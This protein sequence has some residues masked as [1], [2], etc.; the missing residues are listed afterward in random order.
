MECLAPLEVAKLCV[1]E[2]LVVFYLP[3][4]LIYLPMLT[5]H[6]MHHSRSGEK[7]KVRSGF[8][9]GGQDPIMLVALGLAQW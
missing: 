3:T 4:F 7:E 2:D 9:I 8:L 5:A 1:A 6:S